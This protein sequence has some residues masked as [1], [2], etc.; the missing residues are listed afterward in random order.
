[1]AFSYEMAKRDEQVMYKI[2]PGFRLRCD[3]AHE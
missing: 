3:C 1:M 2:A